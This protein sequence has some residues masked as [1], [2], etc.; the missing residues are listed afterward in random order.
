[1]PGA[2]YDISASASQSSAASNS[3]TAAAGAGGSIYN[4]LSWQTAAISAA[5]L[6]AA[7]VVAFVAIR[8]LK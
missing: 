6:I 5:G 7:V 1:M 3:G 8:R 2:G 4:G